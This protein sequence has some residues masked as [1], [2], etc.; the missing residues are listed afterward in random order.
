VNILKAP[1]ARSTSG[2]WVSQKVHA[3][4][5]RGKS[6]HTMFAPLLNSQSQFLVA[7]AI[8]SAPSQK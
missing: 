6:K 1:H 2:S 5:L 3:A 7:G 8:D 4:V